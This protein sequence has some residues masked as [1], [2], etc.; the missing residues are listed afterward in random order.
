MKNKPDLSHVG[1]TRFDQWSMG[2]VCFLVV[3]FFFLPFYIGLSQWPVNLLLYFYLGMLLIF[4]FPLR[5]FIQ[6][7]HNLRLYREGIEIRKPFKPLQ[8]LHWDEIAQIRGSV[9][10]S[11][12]ILTNRAGTVSCQV[13]SS[14]DNVDVLLQLLL[15]ARPDLF[16]TDRP[17]TCTISPIPFFFLALIAIQ[18]FL[19]GIHGVFASSTGPALLIMLSFCLLIFVGALLVIPI[20]ITIL[21]PQLVIRY[22]FRKK[23]LP[24]IDV[25]VIFKN[26]RFDFIYEWGEITIHEKNGNVILLMFYNLGLSLLFGFLYGWHQ[27]ATRPRLSA[28]DALDP[29]PVRGHR[30][31]SKNAPYGL[32]AKIS[33]E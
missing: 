25:M 3:P 21:G 32:P 7:L 28:G 18:L 8:F 12:L 17:L 27:M 15:S 6:T 30:G 33:A 11:D 31:L 26:T 13:N 4:S 22:L 29:K 1:H 10:R 24:A 9:W 16:Q 5:L 23:I 2:A 20:S 19:F 14:Y